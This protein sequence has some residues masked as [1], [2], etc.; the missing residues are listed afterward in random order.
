MPCCAAR[1]VLVKWYL[2]LFPKVSGDMST[3]VIRGARQHNLKSIDLELPRRQVIAVT[4]V[5]GSGKSSLA[6][7]TIYAEGQRRYIESLSTYARQF[8][9]RLGR[10]DV[11]DISG[12]SPTIAIRQKNTV[13]SARST[14]GTATEIYDYLRLLF[15]R[16]GKIFCPDCGL[17]VRAFSPSEAAEHIIR[18]FEGRRVNML[19][20]IGTVTA[21]DWKSKRSYLLSRGY[22]RLL[23]DGAPVRVDEFSVGEEPAVDLAV[24]LGR[25]DVRESNRSRIAEIA[26]LG[27]RETAG[28]VDVADIDGSERHRFT[29]TPLCSKCNRTFETLNPLL[30]SFNSPY[31]ACPDCHGFGDRM[32][33]SEDLIVP[34]KRLTLQERAV[35]P[36][37]RERFSYFHHRMLEFCRR[38]RISTSTPWIELSER[39]KSL[40]LEG[41]G[42]YLGV[43]PFLEKLREKSYKKG[44]RFFTRKY[45]AFTTC[46]TCQGGRLKHEAY[47][48]KV[49][50]CTIRNL[51]RMVPSEILRA[52]EGASLAPR[53]ETIAR[54]VLAELTSRLRFMIDVGLGYLT[55]DRLTRTLS[56]GEAQRINLAN[57]LGANLVDALYILDEP[58]IGLHAADNE[59]LM[60]VLRRLKD[61]GNTVLV[62]EH[63]PEII[64]SCD[65]LVDL[66]PG[67]GRLGGEVLFSG[68]VAEARS[69]EVPRSKT[70]EWVFGKRA[71]D[72]RERRERKPYGEIELKGVREHN[73]KKIDVRFPLGCVTCVTGVSGSGKSTLVVDVLYRLV[74]REPVATSRMKLKSWNVRGRLD[75]VLLVDQSAIGASPRS[76]PITY[77]KAFSFIR[78]IFAGQTLARMR[79]YDPGRFSFNRPGGRCPRCQGMG[80]RKVEMHFMADVFVPCE[81]CEGK[82]FNA[83]TLDVRYKGKNISEA[84]ELTVDEAM[85]FFDGSPQLGEKLWILSKVGLGYLKLGQPSNSLSGGEAQR[86]KIARE[87][88]ESGGQRN[89]YL[90]DEPTTGLHMSDIDT[91]LRVL[92]ELVTAGHSIILIEHNMEVIRWADCVIDLGPGGGEAGG[93]VIACGSPESIIQSEPSITGKFLRAYLEKYG[94]RDR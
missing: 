22:S 23:A 54:D 62:V 1:P 87:L 70:F 35:D 17:E 57:A 56:G 2:A 66:G 71:S 83:E 28:S 63:D 79:G 15:A 73:L 38:K 65:Y 44:H 45:M 60:A 40:I 78:E 75:R 30:F 42:R 18:L 84:L 91:L 72:G 33:F 61:I 69:A 67:P 16:V 50:G 82:R 80:F 29:Q 10:P 49:G 64:Q 53:E 74:S 5:S 13:T 90:M 37:S 55:L 47:Y 41:E 25:V 85:L 59:R 81:E 34:D 20:P 93:T 68:T 6:F 12:I 9:E 76:N 14:V 77:I 52:I 51:V 46:R 32:E 92:E 27:Y 39:A 89:L 26:E 19:V 36:W 24:L 94:G 58:S 21:G 88:T 31:G 43:I 4:G 7:D 86:I 48:V 8:I 3:I 11:D